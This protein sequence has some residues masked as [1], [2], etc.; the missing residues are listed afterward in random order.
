MFFK[1]SDTCLKNGKP[2]SLIDDDKWGMQSSTNF[3]TPMVGQKTICCKGEAVNEKYV[4][5]LLF[6]VKEGLNVS[7]ESPCMLLF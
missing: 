7:K 2:A 3:S 1:K 5:I 6:F 4:P